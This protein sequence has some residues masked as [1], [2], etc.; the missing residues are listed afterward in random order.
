MNYF[1]DDNC[2]K[3]I[4]LELTTFCNLKCKL[5]AHNYTFINNLKTKKVHSVDFWKKI[6]DKYTNLEMVAIAGIL[7]EPT[8]YP[9][10]IDLI[11]YLKIRNIKIELYTNGN[12]HD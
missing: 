8:L 11:D 5:C 10:L 4:S 6:I 3:G 2:V 9:H 1:L 7:S 12:T